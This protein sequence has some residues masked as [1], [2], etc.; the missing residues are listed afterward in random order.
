M[1]LSQS[2]GENEWRYAIY[3][4]EGTW[5]D[6]EL[7]AKSDA[8]NLTMEVAQ[9]GKHDGDLPWESSFFSVA[10]GTLA[11]SAVKKCEDRDSVILRI[12]NP[13]GEDVEATVSAYKPIKQ[14]WLTNMNEE[15]RDEL[16][17]DGSDVPF[18]VPRKK[19]MTL[20]LAF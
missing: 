20:E 4:H 8:F 14:A 15:R 17:P 1:T 10:P 12:F 6:G 13:T 19:I 18:P 16:N 11:L 9:A 5:E 2:L 3:P 7:F